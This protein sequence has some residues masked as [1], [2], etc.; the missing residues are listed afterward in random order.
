MLTSPRTIERA[1]EDAARGTAGFWHLDERGEGPFVSDAELLSTARR[2]ADALLDAGFGP[3]SRIGIAV[4]PTDTFARTFFGAILV[5]CI[6]TPLAEASVLR[7]ANGYVD[8]LHAS[9]VSAR[10]DLLIADTRTTGLWQSTSTGASGRVPI[11]DAASLAV[12]ADAAGLPG[13]ARRL[14]LAEPSGLDDDALVQ[15]T[16]GSTGSPKGIVLTHRSVDANVRGI[17]KALDGH[18]SDI[19]VSWLPLHHDMGLI[20]MLLAPMYID[21]SSVLL[22][23]LAF[24]KRPILWLKT[25]AKYRGAVSFAPSSAFGLAAR[26]VRARDCE[27]LDLSSWRVAGCGA[28]PIDAGA[29]EAFAEAVKACGFRPEAF[30]PCY[31]LAEHVVAACV[32]EPG[33]GLIVDVVSGHELSRRGVAVPCDSADPHARRIVSCGRQLDGHQAAVVD[34]AGSLVAERTL[35]EVVLIGP[36]VMRGYLRSDDSVESPR[37]RILRTGDIGYLADGELYVCGRLKETII[38]AGRNY[39]P[40][41][42]EQTVSAV[43]PFRG[44]QVVA[45]G[46]TPFNAGERV[47]VAIEAPASADNVPNLV[48][49][50][51]M[52]RCGLA[53]D[54]VLVFRPRTLPETTSGK[55]RRLALRDRYERGELTDEIRYRG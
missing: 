11:I 2:V 37:D 26:R 20:G 1:L 36:S 9:L 41:D 30:T 16:S 15:L 18:P 24:V 19:A 47:V 31:G 40:H 8:H 7:D 50:A 17:I 55:P 51:V 53:I 4:G 22:P 46:T 42:I 14:I 23:P 38:F 43:E 45:F 33:R 49:R 34:K 29:L 10:V 12:A 35:G 48:R 25:I 3:G 28:E 32:S 6:V 44:A 52:S 5:G 54:E 27:Q 21:G 39:D 13:M